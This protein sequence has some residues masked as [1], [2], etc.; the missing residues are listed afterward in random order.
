M[1]VASGE[2]GGVREDLRAAVAVA[3]AALRWS[4]RA[5]VCAAEIIAAA[6]R[7]MV[8][9]SRSSAQD[10]VPAFTS[11]EHFFGGGLDPAGG[12]DEHESTVAPPYDID[13]YLKG[14]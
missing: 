11:E 5:E 13:I 14:D 10:A 12:L 4:R 9:I 7:A 8:S 2:P 3:F 1:G 6:E